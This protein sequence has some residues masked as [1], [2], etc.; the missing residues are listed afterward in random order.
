MLTPE[1]QQGLYVY[2]DWYSLLVMCNFVIL[3]TWLEVNRSRDYC[4]FPKTLNGSYRLFANVLFAVF[5]GCLWSSL[6]TV[7]C[8]NYLVLQEICL[9]TYWI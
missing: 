5:D 3:E 1:Y 7:L 4:I 2:G 9:F 8:S 6:S